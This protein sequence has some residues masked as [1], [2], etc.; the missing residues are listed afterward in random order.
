MPVAPE[1]KVKCGAV[2]VKMLADTGTG[3]SK[4]APCRKLLADVHRSEQGRIASA[5]EVLDALYANDA[6][7]GTILKAKTIIE[8]GEWHGPPNEVEVPIEV[9]LLGGEAVTEY[10]AAEEAKQ[11]AA[12]EKFKAAEQPKPDQPGIHASP[13][14]GTK[15]V[16]GPQ[17]AKGR[18]KAAA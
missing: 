13:D 2:L 1:P 15:G 14:F 6:P 9:Q 5:G 17:P 16:V 4:L 3:A 10:K 11:A 18:A 8:T 7:A 12:L